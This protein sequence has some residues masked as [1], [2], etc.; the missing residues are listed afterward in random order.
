MNFQ[1][2]N[3]RFTEP[4]RQQQTAMGYLNSIN[5]SYH[6]MGQMMKSNKMDQFQVVGGMDYAHPPTLDYPHRPQEMSPKPNKFSGEN[7]LNIESQNLNKNFC[8]E[9]DNSEEESKGFSNKNDEVFQQPYSS[10]YRKKEAQP[11]QNRFNTEYKEI[12]YEQP[13]YEGF[14]YRRNVDQNSQMRSDKPVY[15]NMGR[16]Q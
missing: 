16:Y 12:N 3:F 13:K 10:I 9:S 7:L 4:M 1:N 8:Y 14:M 5:N 6:M 2:N 11:M 15:N